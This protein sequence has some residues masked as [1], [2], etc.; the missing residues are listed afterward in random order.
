MS[1]TYRIVRWCAKGAIAA[2]ILMSS[3]CDKAVFR[4]VIFEAK[5]VRLASEPAF[6][7]YDIQS[8][9]SFVHF[10][11][12]LKPTGQL[13]A[14]RI[15]TTHLAAPYSYRGG[16]Y[17]GIGG[18]CAEIIAEPCKIVITFKPTRPIL[19]EDY[20]EITYFGGLKD[21]SVQIPLKGEGTNNATLKFSRDGVEPI[22]TFDFG[23]NSITNPDYATQTIYVLY[24]GAITATAVTF[25]SLTAPFSIINNN[26]P[27]VIN[28]P[29]SFLLRYK[30]TAA[31]TRSQSLKLDYNNGAYATARLQV[32]GTTFASTETPAVLSLTGNNFN[33]TAINTVH[34][35]EFTLTKTS[36]TYSATAISISLTGNSR[37]T[38]GSDGCTG[39]LASGTCTFK[40]VYSPNA[41]RSPDDVT[42]NVSYYD[43]F[44]TRTLT[45]TVEGDCLNKAVLT[46]TPVSQDFS[47]PHIHI[48]QAPTRTFT[49]KNGLNLYRASSIVFSIENDSFGN[50]TIDPAPNCESLE[51]DASCTITIKFKPT[52]SNHQDAK[53]KVT[54][55]ND[56]YAPTAPPAALYSDLSGEGDPRPYL[57]FWQSEYN[58]GTVLIGR[59]STVDLTVEYYGADPASLHAFTWSPVYSSW[60]DAGGT[61]DRSTIEHI[62]TCT[63]TVTFTPTVRGQQDTVLSI[64]YDEAL[65]VPSADGPATITLRGYG[66]NPASLSITDPSAPYNF[67]LVP[68]RYFGTHTFK[69]KNSD[70]ADVNATGISVSGTAPF[71]SALGGTCDG[72]PCTCGTSLAP[73]TECTFSVK[74]E[75]PLAQAYTGTVTVLYQDGLHTPDQSTSRNVSG[76][77]DSKALLL[78]N[79]PSYDF[80]DVTTGTTK[81]ASLT[82]NRYGTVA[83]TSITAIFSDPSAGF[84]FDSIT[85]DAT[86]CTVFI[87]FTPSN[88]LQATSTLRLQYNDGATVQQTNE[89][90]LTGLGRDIA[91]VTIT[92][93]PPSDFDDT[94]INTSRTKIFTLNRTGDRPATGLSMSI[95]GVAP[96]FFSVAGSDCGTDLSGSSCTVTVQFAPTQ[97]GDDWSSTLDVTYNDG[98]DSHTIHQNLVGDSFR[99]AFL[100]LTGSDLGTMDFEGTKET[101]MTL[102]NSGSDDASNVTLSF[103]GTEPNYTIVENNCGSTIPMPPSAN[104]TCTFKVSHNAIDRPGDDSV[105]VRADYIDGPGTAYAEKVIN[106]KAVVKLQVSA[107]GRHTCLRTEIGTV[108][109]W[110][111]NDSGQLGI[112][113]T[114]HKGDNGGEMGTAL[115]AVDLGNVSGI[116]HWARSVVTGAQHSCAVLEDRTVKCWGK[117]S[118]GQL[119]HT[120]KFGANECWGC[121]SNQ[122]GNALPVANLG[123]GLQVDSLT[124][125]YEHTCALFTDG[126]VKCWG[127][128]ALAQLGLGHTENR[129]LDANKMGDALAYVA[130]G[131]DPVIQISASPGHTC[132]LIQGGVVKCWG[133]NFYGQLGQGDIR[134]RG[135]EPGEIEALQPINLGTDVT[136]LSVAAASG[137]TCVLTNNHEVKCWGKNDAT[138]NLGTVWC[139]NNNNVVGSCEDPSYPILLEGYG[140]KSV[141]MGDNL[142]HVE[143]GG[144]AT[145]LVGGS[146]HACV[147]LTGGSVK[148]WGSNDYGQI[149]I[150]KAE[151]RGAIAAQM[152]SLLETVQLGVGL[153]TSISS[154]NDHVCVI[155]GNTAG[156][157]SVKCWGHNQFGALGKGDTDNRG[158]TAGQMGSS[159]TPI[160][161]Q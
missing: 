7:D 25:Q 33:A 119:G 61:C 86:S 76:T 21:E 116:P 112:G 154:Q 148:C 1:H 69:L 147:L 133:Y 31:R 152:G 34:E 139:Y 32:S 64:P 48:N 11:F 30:D 137:F 156:A 123:T 5:E 46:L 62:I 23:S 150:G 83:P 81:N 50:Y 101:Q 65:G 51:S 24:Y 155:L 160:I 87:H 121:G 43:G 39:T 89:I 98:I 71:S 18:T 29:C 72:V 102:T 22:D 131:T 53:L 60:I 12:E 35:G 59:S 38:L 14:E 105:T 149:G 77:G 20:I 145:A 70:L 47:N 132:A 49:L 41:V 55:E 37:Y 141:M 66:G 93:V 122:M 143:F 110:G 90:G 80:L 114:T 75:P 159:L 57:K 111:R 153:V 117:N 140:R 27:G 79:D 58:F 36:G 115:L 8:I 63:V 107:N 88:N 134:T 109:C 67:G 68:A 54:Y 100:T 82:V 56:D 17:P 74:F 103:V 10:T 19:Y 136:A 99:A 44:T 97:V 3:A 128:N 45:R 113:N 138:G 146:Y 127:Q 4:A 52:V 95:S 9:N 161:Y 118:A 6:H 94:R 158:T 16:S 13:Y 15:R 142:P 73:N 104:S 85:C 2:L 120:L 129:G 96:V 144:T 84:Y 28:E 125:G 124:A 135:D 92:T 130:L 157:Q 108:K 26:C 78:F 91:V 40:V 42:L 151:N 106:R 126:R